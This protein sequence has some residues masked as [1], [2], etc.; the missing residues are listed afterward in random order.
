MEVRGEGGTTAVGWGETPL[1]VQWVWPSSSPYS[2]REGCLIEFTTALAQKLVDSGLSGHPIEIGWEFG[3]GLLHDLLEEANAIRLENPMPHLAA[4]VCF[5]AYDIALHDAYGRLCG[6]PVYDCYWKGHLGRD[7]TSFLEPAPGS[8][9]SF[10]N[11]HVSDFLLET[12]RV[13]M[14]AWHL[15]G[16]LDPLTEADLAGDEPDDSYPVT[17]EQWIERDGLTSLKIKL[18]GNDASWDYD[19]LVATGEIGGRLGVEALTAD[20]NCTV[21]EPDYVNEIIDRLAAEHPAIHR[22][23]LYIEQPFPYDL[24]EHRIDVRSV[25]GRLPLYLDES[26]HDWRLVRLG[27]SLG[28]TGVAL[29]TCKTQTGALLS[30]CWAQAHGMG[31][32]VQD[33]TNPMLAQIPHLS[34]AAHL[35]T[36][37]GVETNGMQ[38]YPRGLRARGRSASRLLCAPGRPGRPLDPGR[39]WLRLPRGGGGSGA[40]GAGG[41]G[42]VGRRS[43]LTSATMPR[44]APPPRPGGRRA[45]ARSSFGGRSDNRPY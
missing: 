6:M 13:R 38:F 42:P 30:A 22:Q 44:P 27:R 14:P 32:M 19:R 25:S 8:D 35:P 26:A 41:G 3:E 11:K 5:S 23:I 43:G 40:P 34:L 2:E 39:E 1:S 31:L 4:L 37:R 17:L 28:W 12:P 21:T 29:K 33:L 18:R 45:P 10:A 16:G 9:V 15:V 20:F 36:I 7:L 24:E